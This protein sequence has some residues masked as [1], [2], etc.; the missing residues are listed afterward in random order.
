MSINSNPEDQPTLFSGTARIPDLPNQPI[1]VIS[2]SS[3]QYTPNKFISKYGAIARRVG[4]RGS[5]QGGL[6][7][8]RVQIRGP[9]R[10][11][12]SVATGGSATLDENTTQYIVAGLKNAFAAG[13]NTHLSALLFAP[14]QS[15]E[16]DKL[17]SELDNI[18]S[19]LHDIDISIAGMQ[20][21][22]DKTREA[23][24]S[25]LTELKQL[26]A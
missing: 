5:L 8:R 6:S 7:S 10:I 12:H 22:I 11:E 1:I 9:Q 19:D 20:N 13:P 18:F 25:I 16:S 15:H 26:N 24:R 17:I 3:T 4:G 21:S 14:D 23:T 2:I